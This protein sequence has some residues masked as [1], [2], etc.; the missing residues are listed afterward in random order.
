MLYVCILYVLG[1]SGLLFSKG[2]AEILKLDHHNY[3]YICFYNIVALKAI[4]SFIRW[5]ISH[6]TAKILIAGKHQLV[7]MICKIHFLVICS[8]QEYISSWGHWRL[9]QTKYNR[10][11]SVT[12]GYYKCFL[13]NVLLMFDQRTIF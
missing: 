9:S 4:K 6:N 1:M 2:S 12:C 13:L 10:S 11:M 5:P 8:W 3:T 7:S